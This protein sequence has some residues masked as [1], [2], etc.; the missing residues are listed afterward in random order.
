MKGNKM[1]AILAI[2]LMLSGAV[3]VPHAFAQTPADAIQCNPANISWTYPAHAPGGPGDTWTMYADVVNVQDLFLFQIGFYF[4]PTAVQIV[5]VAEGGF[6]SANGVDS[7]LAFPGTI[8]NVNG[9]VI[10]YG[11]SLTDTNLAKSGTGHLITVQAKINP[12][13]IPPIGPVPMMDLTTVDGDPVETILLYNDGISDISPLESNV[14]D[15]MFTLS[16]VATGPT[17]KFTMSPPPYYVNIAETDDATTS[18]PGFDGINILPI[19]NYHW[20]FGDGNTLDTANPITTHAYVAAGPYTVTL[21]VTDSIGETDTI[22]HDKVVLT[23]PTGCVIDVFTQ[24]WRYIDPT[25]Y[26]GVLQGK[27]PGYPAEL[28]RPGD[29]V[30]LYTTTIY[31]GDPV[32]GQLVSYEVYDNNG[33]LVLAGVATGNENGLAEYDFRIPWPCPPAGAESM[34]GTWTVYVTWEIG[35]NDPNEPPFAKT[36]NDTLTFN[37]GWGIWSDG[38]STDKTEYYKSEMVVIKVNIHNDYS[39]PIDAL[40]TADIF[41]DLM[42]PIG[43]VAYVMQTFPANSV[44]EVT[45]PGI[46]VEKWAFAGLGTVKANEFSTWPSV[47]GTAFCPEQV[48]TFVIK[49]TFNPPDP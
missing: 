36:Q 23:A 15:G 35:T 28:F 5:S 47:M 40:C 9:K 16:V 38:L 13:L 19:V 29:Y 49:Q 2:L 41:D 10:P 46:H 44:T 8:D 17:A 25:T 39:I 20:D 12:A 30:Q 26:T 43:G 3:I 31:N 33:I 14:V 11:W 22:S 4:D 45:F 42:V 34:F 21:T 7:L 32:Q 18:L 37:V 6:L 48:A 27:G 24:G 1:S